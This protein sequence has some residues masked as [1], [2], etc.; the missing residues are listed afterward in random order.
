MRL[1]CGPVD[2]G[3]GAVGGG[4][5]AQASAARSASTAKVVA[6]ASG[7]RAGAASGATA[8][9][10]APLSAR[11]SAFKTNST[12]V[13]TGLPGLAAMDRAGAF[14]L[15]RIPD[16]LP[17]FRGFG[18][19]TSSRF[20]LV[21]HRTPC[22]AYRAHRMA[23]SRQLG[24]AGLAVMRA[25]PRR[26][27]ASA[28]CDVRHPVRGSHAGRCRPGLRPDRAWPGAPSG[29]ARASPG[30]LTDRVHG[31]AARRCQAGCLLW[32][33]VLL[34]SWAPRSS[35]VLSPVHAP[36]APC[37]I[38]GGALAWLRWQISVASKGC[39][40]P[41]FSI[42]A[43]RLR[44]PAGGAEWVRAAQLSERQ[45]DLPQPLCVR[46]SGAGYAV[47]GSSLGS[48]S[49]SARRNRPAGRAGHA[50][51]ARRRA[52]GVPSWCGSQPGADDDHE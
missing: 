7:Q 25:R 30:P 27:P 13:E 46:P 42:H 31:A 1:G 37:S 47:G 50:F 41:T 17:P 40:S 5:D 35:L 4:Q 16:T 8:L 21:G 38:G 45:Q 28:V 6:S 9:H 3:R 20:A 49:E 48:S 43:S 26:V 11:S 34:W 12:G 22:G 29:R 15:R 51:V 32:P 18:R 23:I 2:S 14:T 44:R 19:K 10:A 39:C 24:P 52:C 36:L 33:V